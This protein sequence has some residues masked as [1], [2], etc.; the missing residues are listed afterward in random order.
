MVEIVIF[1]DGDHASYDYLRVIS[2]ICVDNGFDSPGWFSWWGG[3]PRQGCQTS[4]CA[5]V[6]M[7][8]LV[9]NDVNDKHK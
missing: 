1:Q 6:D 5:A 3:A 7:M 9:G 4:G 8:M 2:D